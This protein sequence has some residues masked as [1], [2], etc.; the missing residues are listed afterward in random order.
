MSTHDLSSFVGIQSRRQVESEDLEIRAVT[1]STVA[2][3]KDDNT[4][5][6]SKGSEKG[7]IDGA[8]NFKI[9]LFIL[10]LKKSRNDLVISA[11]DSK[12][13]RELIT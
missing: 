5:G 1:S 2:G 8:G 3:E 6:V 10:L 12:V 13:G 4:G 7:S 11:R 9:K